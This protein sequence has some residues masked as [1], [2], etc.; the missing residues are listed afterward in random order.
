MAAAVHPAAPHHLPGFLPGPDGSDPLFAA[1]AIG[2]A[3]LLLMLGNVY[4]RLHSL[5]ERLAHRSSNTQFQLVAILGLL[6]LVTHNT[7]F[8]VAALVLATIQLPDVTGPLNAIAEALRRPGRPEPR[9]PAPEAAAD[10]RPE[11]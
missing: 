2:L 7:L 10:S 8:W 11:G 3:L 4:F 6:A 5:P 9:G 1:T